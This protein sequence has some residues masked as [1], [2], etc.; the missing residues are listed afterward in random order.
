MITKKSG[1]TIVELLIVIVVI[2]ILAAISIVAYQGIQQRANNTATISAV[3]Q[4][5]R[6]IQAYVG[7]NGSYPLT[8]GGTICVTTTSGCYG[9][10]GAFPSNSTFNTN[11]SGIGTLPKS[12][13][14]SGSSRYG[15]SYDY[16]AGR[17]L[18]GQSRPAMLL[19]Y[20]QGTYQQCGMPVTNSWGPAM[21]IASSGYTTGDT[22]DGKTSCIVSISGL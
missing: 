12:V 16:D 3:N 6:A 15:I 9:G 5:L 19:Y 4:T 10:A 14:M 13:P 17:T 1:F 20:L 8:V 21:S 11:M 2:A 7:S 18:S 22:G